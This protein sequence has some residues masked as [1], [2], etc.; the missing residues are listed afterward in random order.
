MAIVQI[1][2]IQQRS[3]NLVDLPQL[4]EAQFGFASDAKRLFIGKTTGDVEN[5]EV[6]TSYSNISFSQINGSDGGNFNISN[7]QNGQILTYVSSTDTWENYT[8]NTS[9]LNGDKLQLG[10]AANLKIEGGAIGYVL[11]TDGLGNLSWTPKGTLY[12]PIEALDPVGFIG[13]IEIS[14]INAGSFIVGVAYSINAVGTTTDWFAIGATSNTS[15]TTFIATAAG[16]G[17]GTADET[18]LNISASNSGNVKVGMYITGNSIL[19]GT[20]IAALGTGNGTTGSYFLNQPQGANIATQSFNGPIIMTVANTTPYVSGTSVT[21]SG[22]EG[23]A[24]ANVNGQVFYLTLANDYPTTG[25]VE[26]YTDVGRTTPSN[27]TNLEY[28]NPNNAIATSVIAGGGGGSATAG[29]ANQQVQF[30]N[31]NLLDGDPGFTYNYLS[32]LVTVTANI[33]TGNLN[34]NGTLTASRLVSNIPTGTAPLTVASTTRVVNLNVSYSNVSDF[35]VVTAQTTGTFYPVFV[36]GNSTANYALGANSNLSFNAATGNLNTTLLNVTSNANLGNLGVAGI[37]IV[38]G[39]ISGGNISTA[40]ILTATGNLSGGNISTAGVLSVTG[41]ANVGNL[42]TAGLITAT[43]NISGG[44]LTTT[45]IVAATGNVTAGNVY[46]NSGTIG[47]TLLTGTLTTNAQPNITSTG[48]LTSLAVTGNTTSGNVYANSGTIGA[49]LLTGTLTTASQPNVTSVGSLTGLTIAANGDIT[50]SGTGSQL[51]GANLVSASYLT[52]TL[53]TA[54]QPNITSTGTLTSLTVTGSVTGGNLIT[55][56]NGNIGTLRVTGTSNLGPVSNVTI[57]G[58]NANQILKTNG[59]GTLSWTDPTGGYY[60]HTQ[61]IASNTWT[62]VHNLNNQYLSVDPIDS[63]G[64][65]YMGRYDYPTVN[66][67]NANAVT[68]T[69]TSAVTGYCAIVGGGF[70]YAN[71]NGTATPAGLDTYVQF[72]DS[73]T[74]GGQPS[75]VF[76]KTTGTVSATIFAGS[77]ANLTNLNASNVSSGTLAQARLANSTLTLGNTILTLGA[78]TTT[79]AGL[80]SVTSTSFT[81]ALTGAATTAGTVTTAAQPN[82]TSTGTLTSL[83]VSGN[84][85][86]P[87]ITANTGVFT[88]NGSGLSAINASNISSGTL[89][90][91][92]LANASLTLGNTSLTLGGTTTTVTG[93]TS[94]TS[95]AFVGALT[96]AAT[97]ATTA[98]TVTTAAQPNITSLG[99]LTGLTLANAA[100][101]S[102]G[103]NT[104]VGT[105]TGNFVLSSGSKLQATYA[106]LAEYYQADQNYVPGTVLEF[107]GDKEVTL[108]SDETRRVAGV[109]STNPA[110]AMNAECPGIAVAIALQGR[111]PVKVRGN[112]KKGDMLVSG[113]N[114]YAR[115]THDPKLGTIIGKALENF[116]GTDGIIEI[117][118]G[119]L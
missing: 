29:G 37:A 108:A 27:G 42:G 103:S 94:V 43:G 113:G 112:I 109:V 28:D 118:V 46:A 24:N 65:S 90:Q 73:G 9:Q 7:A 78:T 31:T 95:T 49:S 119:R 20:Y 53:T 75:F 1:S 36:N 81:G 39:N 16:S 19:S 40:G 98:G 11:E 77:G 51:S 115:P 60:L 2:K 107:G 104:N 34:S 92:R 74:L 101:I 38:T 23:N 32:G 87:N 99:T 26:L 33:T 50:M 4:D 83:V 35:E 68:L 79:V 116:E 48:T 59:S 52:G 105:L 25:N 17:D 8:G 56:G 69:F 89:A 58:G 10:D 84:I 114:G 85:T 22:V 100:V 55:T 71:G 3:G 106:D 15:G 63:T 14:V 44:N 30:N 111:V 6:L 62:I 13:N 93:L 91:A 76:N 47:A 67:T 18:E 70:T 97:S 57:T 12:T 21:I 64:N 110:Y 5:I 88:G 80:T 82:I 102:M 86:A 54:A 72:N 66:Y 96:G 41:N 61:S 117:A 45:G